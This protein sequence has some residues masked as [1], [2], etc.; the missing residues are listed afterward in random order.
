MDVLVDLPHFMHLLLAGLAVWGRALVPELLPTPLP[1]EL[2]E[3]VV[4][5]RVI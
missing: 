1:R 5:E 2:S 4:A 3:G